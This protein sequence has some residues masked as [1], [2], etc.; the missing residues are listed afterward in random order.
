ML[1]LALA[2]RA[3][4]LANAGAETHSGVL[5]DGDGT[6]KNTGEEG[7]QKR[8]E[9]NAPVNANFTNARKP[10]GSDRGEDA[11]R[12]V[13]E[14]QADGAAEQSE[15]DAFEEKV[16][17]DAC[18]TGAQCG[19]HSQLLTAAFDADQQQ[20]GDV[21]A[22]NQKDHADGA[23]E[24]PENAAHVA[25]DITFERTD[26]GADVGIFEELDA[27]AGRSGERTHDNRKHVSNV[28]VDLLDGDA[29]LQP[30]K[31]LITKVAKMGFVTVKLE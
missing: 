6:K 13:G 11:Q 23:H 26:V 10:R 15:N 12:T 22:G 14:A 25:D 18:A 7:N 28:G 5:E 31:T 9:Q 20:V 3:S 17:S 24:N 2:E 4:A 8:E 29:W 19:A 1:L 27:E 16:G 30:G 21:G